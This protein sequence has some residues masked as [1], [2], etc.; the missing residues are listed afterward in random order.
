MKMTQT[1]MRK[2]LSG[3]R[4]LMGLV[5]LTLPFVACQAPQEEPA[6]DTAPAAAMHETTEE[7]QPDMAGDEAMAGDESGQEMNG[8]TDESMGED[9]GM[10]DDMHGDMGDDGHGDT[11]SEEGSEGS[12]PIK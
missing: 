8:E 3:L 2:A 10:G 11:G 5:L 1:T 4:L 9:D 7:A 12:E 6:T